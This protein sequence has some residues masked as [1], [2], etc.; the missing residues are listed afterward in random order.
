MDGLF[1]KEIR[2]RKAFENEFSELAKFLPT[3]QEQALDFLLDVQSKMYFERA[4]ER[5][6]KSHE[7]FL[8]FNELVD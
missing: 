4:D 2:V 8:L 5:R 6:R 7:F 3:I 1:H